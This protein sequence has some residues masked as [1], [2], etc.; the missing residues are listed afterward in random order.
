MSTPHCTGPGCRQGRAACPT[1]E[2]CGMPRFPTTFEPDYGIEHFRKPSALM[3]WA[4]RIA[5]VVAGTAVL[6]CASF[7]IGAIGR[8]RG[9]W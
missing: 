3:T 2:A 1:P 4:W 5:S 7:A 8:A 9:W 6:A